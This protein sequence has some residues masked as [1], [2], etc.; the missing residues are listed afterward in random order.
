MEDKQNKTSPYPTLI[1]IQKQKY[2]TYRKISKTEK[3]EI[4]TK[5]EEEEQNKKPLDIPN[6]VAHVLRRSKIQH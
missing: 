1:K 3:Q 5:E 4:S 2:Q 6:E